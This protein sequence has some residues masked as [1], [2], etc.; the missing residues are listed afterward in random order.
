VQQGVWHC[1]TPLVQT[2]PPPSQFPRLFRNGPVSA[3]RVGTIRVTAKQRWLQL[4]S[5]NNNNNS[6]FGAK[7]GDFLTFLVLLSGTTFEL[8]LERTSFPHHLHSMHLK[9]DYK[10]R[11]PCNN[12]QFSSKIVLEKDVKRKYADFILIFGCEKKEPCT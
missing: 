7:N 6:V 11:L 8:K 3:I 10:P 1:L 9:N 2:T 4:R 5:D 12:T